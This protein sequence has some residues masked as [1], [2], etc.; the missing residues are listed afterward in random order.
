MSADVLR[1]ELMIQL[2]E[3]AKYYAVI[4]YLRELE[5]VE[6]DMKSINRYVSREMHVN[7]AWRDL[8]DRSP[9]RQVSRLR[10]DR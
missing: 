3:T 7:L 9:P 4:D 10:H 2:M 8:L 5:H 6:A 1:Q